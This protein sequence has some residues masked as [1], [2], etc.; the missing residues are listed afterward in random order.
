MRP[1]RILWFIVLIL[2]QASMAHSSV[3]TIRTGQTGGVPGVCPGLDDSFRYFAPEPQCALPLLSTPFQSSDFDRACSGPSA[4][5]VDAYGGVWAD[6]LNCDP[7]ARWIANTVIPG[8]CWGNSVSVLYCAEFNNDSE[9]TMADSV[10]VCWVT[11]DALGDPA[12]FGPNPGGVYING[13]S[14]GPAF[15]GGNYATETVATAY[16]VPIQ[17]GLNS[18]EVYQRDLGCAVAG[19][20]LSATIYV[21]CTPVPAQRSSWGA[22]KALYR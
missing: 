12:G 17:T 16:N 7:E 15:A 19:V 22:V 5:V 3:I 11:D 18:F 13:A 8:T 10:K 20:M 2:V 14:L 1:S 6:H 4:V 21:D 9:C